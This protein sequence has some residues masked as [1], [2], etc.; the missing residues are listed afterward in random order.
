M[1]HS[2]FSAQKKRITTFIC[3]YTK[4]IKAVYSDTANSTVFDTICIVFYDNIFAVDT[5]NFCCQRTQ[6]SSSELLSLSQES[7]E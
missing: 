3:F 7:V 2:L 6:I 4:F 5:K 1:R